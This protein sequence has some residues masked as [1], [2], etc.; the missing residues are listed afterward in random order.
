MG[1]AQK[2]TSNILMTTSTIISRTLGGGTVYIRQREVA[3]VDIT[4]IWITCRKLHGY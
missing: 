1:K 4:R 2:G 3:M